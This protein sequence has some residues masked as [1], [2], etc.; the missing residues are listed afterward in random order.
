MPINFGRIAA[1]NARLEQIVK[2]IG[3]MAAAGT[4]N[5]GNPRFD[6]L[7]D[8]QKRLTDEVGRIHGEGMADS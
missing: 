4:A 7:M 6:A 8:E 1:I 5:A 3:D 2:L